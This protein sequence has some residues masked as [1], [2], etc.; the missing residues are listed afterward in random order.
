[1]KNNKIIDITQYLEDDLMDSSVSVIDFVY[2]GSEGFRDLTDYVENEGAS[3]IIHE[4]RGM[5]GVDFSKTY[6]KLMEFVKPK[7]IRTNNSAADD[8]DRQ[9]HIKI[10]QRLPDGEIRE[11]EINKKQ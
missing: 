11:I 9:V 10:M 5:N 7:L 6:L 8:K 1:M 2:N 4:L 3:R